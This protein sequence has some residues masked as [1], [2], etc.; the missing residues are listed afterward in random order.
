MRPLP[1][2]KSRALV[3]ILL[4]LSTAILSQE[5]PRRIP[6]GMFLPNFRDVEIADFLKTMAQVT[7]RN[8]LVDDSIKGKITVVAYKPIPVSEALAFMKRVLEVR[9]FAV[10]EEGGLIKISKTTEAVSQSETKSAL[11]EKDADIITSVYRVPEYASV[12]E[13]LAF[14]QKIGGKDVVVEPFRSSNTIVLSGYAPRIKRMMELAGEVLPPE[15]EKKTAGATEG[16]HIYQV[17]NLQA[18]SLASVLVKLDAPVLDGDGKDGKPPQAGKIRAVAHKESNTIIITAGREEWT[19][20]RRIIEQLDRERKQILLEVLI[21]E[22]SGK[23]TKDFGIDWRVTS[24]T[25][26]HSQF[27]S[28]LAVEGS[29]LDSNGNITGNNTLSGFSVGFLKKGGDLLGI[30]N[31]NI[32]NQNFNVLSAPQILTL[33]NQ[34]AEINV[35]QDVPVKTQERTS[36]GGTSESTVNSFEYRPSGIKLKF[37]PNIN[38]NGNIVL[39][40]FS[41]VT[42]IEGGSSSTVNPTFNK[43]NIKTFITVDNGQ[44]VVIGGLVSTERLQAVKKIP[45]LGDIPLL[46]FIFRRT[47]FETKRTNLMVFLTPIILNDRET[48]DGLTRMKRSQ[49]I[50]MGRILQEDIRLWPQ[51]RVPLLREENGKKGQDHEIYIFD[52]ENRPARE[53]KKPADEKPK[54]EE[55]RKDE[56]PGMNIEKETRESYYRKKK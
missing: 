11:D 45:L 7:R 26:G 16:V 52:P 9:G 48:A 49:Q 50:D 33:D 53:E 22:V 37:T 18:E 44:T 39:E 2:V 43:R 4:L 10:I 41:E 32:A 14:F 25:A 24:T 5:P 8:I 12:N 27:N 31:A 23:D 34:E 40:L 3:L 1:A 13:I 6:D 38:S 46:G 20:I 29:M 55:L 56:T 51:K 21:A 19:E 28:G 30:F 42:N 36:G 17:M 54:L 35:G 15:K 47:T